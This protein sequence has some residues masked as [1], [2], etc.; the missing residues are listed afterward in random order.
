MG[1]A[2]VVSGCTRFLRNEISRDV[3]NMH[4]FRVGNVLIGV[5]EI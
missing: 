1:S 4:T 2:K 3:V 5:V